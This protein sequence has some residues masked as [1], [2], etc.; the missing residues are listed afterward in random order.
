MLANQ[1]K[2]LSKDWTSGRLS[3]FEFLMKMNILAGRSFNDV[4]RYPVFPW[5]L[6]DYTSATLDLNNPASF[7]DLSKPMG[8][9]HP[10]RQQH[11]EQRYNEWEEDENQSPAF[12]YGTHYSTS[13]HVL[14]YL[15]RLE[16]YCSMH[17]ALQ[18]GVFDQPD[19][20]FH[21]LH[22]TWEATAGNLNTTEVKELIPEMFYLA[23]L[24]QNDAKL[25]LGE[26]QDGVRVDAVLL[27][28]WAHGDASEFVRLHRAA[29]ES[30]HVSA[31]L[32]HWIDLIFGYKQRG[33]SAVQAVNVFH[34]LTYQGAVDVS[35]ITDPTQYQAV[36]SQ[37]THFGQ[38]PK[39]LLQRPHPARVTT[40][41]YSAICNP[42]LLHAIEVEVGMMVGDVLTQNDKVL[43]IGFGSVLLQPSGHLCLI[44]DIRHPG[45]VSVVVTETKKTIGL[46]QGLHLGLVTAMA[47]SSDSSVL[48]TG[49]QDGVVR[50]WDLSAH[51]WWAV[52]PRLLGRH[53]DRL[54]GH[55]G[56]V[57]VL[58][59]S[60]SQGMVVSGG[61]DATAL[62]WDLARSTLLHVLRGHK[63]ALVGVAIDDENG[64]ILTCS[65]SC[66]Q[67]WSING[68]RLATM[69][70][71]AC[72]AFTTEVQSCAARQGCIWTPDTIVLS[73]HCDGRI[74][75]WKLVPTH[76]AKREG[77]IPHLLAAPTSTASSSI[78]PRVLAPM[79]TLYASAQ[80]VTVL[81]FSPDC[82]E[83]VSGHERGQCS[84]WRISEV[85][86]IMDQVRLVLLQDPALV[87]PQTISL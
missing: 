46:M 39:Q 18:G 87:S 79:W 34:Y 67:A 13:A 41:G 42:E 63:D 44:P 6:A 21:S 65:A 58:A 80:A 49:G 10:K 32:H 14:H 62:V 60:S 50:L 73:G 66:I 31:N 82:R 54:V 86:P 59:V 51:A 26:R 56:T 30:V 29:L 12:H 19:R 4:S 53:S 75:F 23:D 78:C 57:V 69:Q 24:F 47:V 16:P 71:H 40:P 35:A 84:V 33:K 7:R 8:C 38:C 27:P 28:P 22:Q 25:P 61:D 85:R 2:L 48:A 15:V 3:N 20:L 68:E 55:Q 64:T 43:A 17:K 74:T 72:S 9:Q 81:R 37:M 70:R 76:R 11:F 5:V 1:R 77:T 83:L 36:L 52:S 45:A